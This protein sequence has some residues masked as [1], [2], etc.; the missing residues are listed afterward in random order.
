[1]INDAKSYDFFLPQEKKEE[2]YNF[3]INNLAS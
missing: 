3:K 1:M 2:N